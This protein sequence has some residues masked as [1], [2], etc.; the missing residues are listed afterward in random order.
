M[1]DKKLYNKLRMQPGQSVLILNSP[2]DYENI[3]DS[4]PEEII[5]ADPNEGEVDFVHL[6]VK[7]K[8][9]LEQFIG[10]ALKSIKFDGLLW[11]SY[12]K[13][14]SKVETDLN[15]D[16]LWNLLK[17]KGIRP[18]TQISIDGTWSA[19]RFRPIDQV[20]E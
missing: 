11:I 1:S 13:G 17:D 3:L 2:R 4:F 5:F 10:K 12:P 15:R 14:S 7:N 16:I 6:F 19:M 9:E 8:N 20:G 18:V